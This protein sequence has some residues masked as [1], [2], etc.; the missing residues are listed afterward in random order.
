MLLK[1]LRYG[2]AEEGEGIAEYA[3]MLAVVLALVVGTIQ[4]IGI[5][6]GHVF[7]D[8]ASALR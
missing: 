3:V 5:R 1:F 6:T 7:S 4:F 2:C 8:I